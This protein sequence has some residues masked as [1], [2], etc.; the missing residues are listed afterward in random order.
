[1]SSEL[2]VIEIEGLGKTY[3]VP[4]TAT[5][6]M[7]GL[8]EGLRRRAAR[9]GS[10]R[11]G[12]APLDDPED[13][14]ELED[15]RE[16]EPVAEPVGH[17]REVVALR[18]VDLRIG[19]G[20]AVGITGPV[21][22][23]KSTL[24]RI[25]GRVSPP[26]VGRVLVRGRVAPL[27]DL[28]SGFLTQA[29]TGR[30]NAF[31]IAR[32]FGVPAEVVERQLEAIFAF[33]GL[34]AKIDHPA[35][36]YSAGQYRRLG[37]AIA[38]HLETDVL[39][40][41]EQL[42][43]GDSEFE[44]SCRDRLLCLREAGQTLLFV[45]RNTKRLRA[46]CDELVLMND[47][48]VVAHGKPDDVLASGEAAPEA[49]RP[50]ASDDSALRA[51]LQL[52]LVHG[53]SRQELANLLRIDESAVQRRV[54]EGVLRIAPRAGSVP[55]RVRKDILEFLLGSC[56]V[57]RAE[58]LGDELAG[59]A[60]ARAWAVAVRGALIDLAGDAA[61]QAPEL[62]DRRYPAGPRWKLT[63]MDLL[64]DIE[65]EAGADH[66]RMLLA[67]AQR[68]ATRREASAVTL[69]DVADAAGMPI[70][71]AKRRVG[72]IRARALQGAEADDGRLAEPD[73]QL[74]ARLFGPD[75]EATTAI[76]RSDASTI[77][78]LVCTYAPDVSTLCRLTLK[79]RSG[80]GLRMAQPEESVAREPGWHRITVDIPPD[81]F[82]DGTMTVRVSVRLRHGRR[83]MTLDEDDILE[84]EVVGD[85]EDSAQEQQNLIDPT[86]TLTPVHRLPDA[87]GNR[88]TEL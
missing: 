47:G 10:L 23:G 25:I 82:P 16:P 72:A 11:P 85:V 56:S 51:L 41:D 87:E 5:S 80:T 62:P 31:L 34:E 35:G 61:A 39:L 74:V 17:P 18:D 2:P 24:L 63:A 3:R 70:K 8:A 79:A 43:R 32:L 83:R 58:G 12:S 40:A 37:Y 26:S 9:A 27:L 76:R 86:W 55:T 84:F 68:S 15:D 22:S 1:M 14:E 65:R 20:R 36:R 81:T 30:Q 4:A 33:A 7:A 59:N 57:A 44:Q 73:T 49:A 60:D 19:R 66:V 71:E 45:S 46:T 21:G 77:A 29:A 42:I 28:S 50:G 53:K 78:V 52:Q 13:E 69:L 88:R 38:L 64:E 48:R 75:G 54:E 6:G 67:R